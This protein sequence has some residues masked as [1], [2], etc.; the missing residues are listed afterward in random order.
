M[1]IRRLKVNMPGG[2]SYEV[3]IGKGTLKRFGECLREINDSKRCL[4][5]SDN[6]VGNLYG[7][8][9]RKVL[10]AAGYEVVDLAMPDGE[11]NK[12]LEVAGELWAAMAEVGFQRDDLVVA[13]GGGVVT[14]M[15]GFVAST[16]MRGVEFVML[17]TT[18]LAMVDASVGGKN[19]LNIAGHKNLVGTFQ[20]PSYVLIDLSFLSTL[21]ER[22][23]LSA[24]AEIAKCSIMGN[25]QFFSWFVENRGKLMEADE[26]T[27][28]QAVIRCIEYKA[29]I[30]AKDE[31][32]KDGTRE[33]LNYGHTLAHA[34]ESATNYDGTVTHG[35]AVAEGMR[36]AARLAAELLGTE[37]SF[38]TDQDA[39]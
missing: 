17:P 11:E 27:I 34:I 36:F 24:F 3:R 4:L 21:P 29:A 7:K 6:T 12:S 14:D 30:V 2:V 22:Q 16:Y 19:G 1:S 23:W 15:C 32:E 9:V 35:E 10:E 39:L 37:I 18:L 33:V 5:L 31:K 20:Q 28:Q 13:L 25:N 8:R 38:V 26:E